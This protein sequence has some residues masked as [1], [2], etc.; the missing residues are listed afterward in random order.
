MS[1]QPADADDASD[2]HIRVLA[3]QKVEPIGILADEVIEPPVDLSTMFRTLD[4]F[5]LLQDEQQR[6]RVL[7]AGGFGDVYLANDVIL[8]RPVAVKLLKTE[9]ATDREQVNQFFQEGVLTSRLQHPGILPVHAMGLWQGRPAI[10]MKVVDGKTLTQYLFE[11]RQSA[12]LSTT[13]VVD[14][15]LQV[16]RAVAYAHAQLTLH[17]DLKPSNVMIGAQDEI[18]VMDWGLGRLGENANQAVHRAGTPAYMPPEQ[19]RGITGEIG[20]ATDVFSLGAMLTEILTGKPP[21][22]ATSKVRMIHMAQTADL[23]ECFQR[24]NDLEN[25]DPALA[26]LTGLA[27]WCLS[28]KAEQRPR[29]AGMVV[30]VLTNYQEG[31][32]LQVQQEIVDRAEREQQALVARARA[33]AR[34]TILSTVALVVFVAMATGIWRLATIQARNAGFQL[35]LVKIGQ[36]IRDGSPVAMEQ[37]RRDLAVLTSRTADG[38]VS[39]INQQLMQQAQADLDF[40]EQRDK[41]RQS[42]AELTNGME[43]NTGTALQY[44]A[45]FEQYGILIKEPDDAVKRIRSSR[46]RPELLTGLD[47]WSLVA[48]DIQKPLLWQ[49]ARDA[50]EPGWFQKFRT[51]VLRSDPAALRVL[52]SELPWGDLRA[53]EFESAARGL[54]QQGLRAES[55]TVL[56]KAVQRYPNDFWLN[57][58]LGQEIAATGSGPDPLK[59][60][61]SHASEAVS[62]LRAALA[63]K[64]NAYVYTEIARI[65][66]AGGD[67]DVAEVAAN[68]ALKIDI[69][70]I[71]ARFY[72]AKIQSVRN[73]PGQAASIARQA[74]GMVASQSPMQQSEWSRRLNEFLKQMEAAADDP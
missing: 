25:L 32:R 63:L 23:G 15:F 47:H 46:I 66:L 61:A 37:A 27:R 1:P 52:V 51:P 59:I 12:T 40:I 68:Q 49:V 18:Q 72:L 31:L 28:E 73:E 9:H 19:A 43:L 10:V 26:P 17:L 36:L 33:R 11:Q 69:N 35:D 65:A 4:G 38:A 41:V 48:D 62:Y 67:L 2:L 74:L 50:S 7:G 39:R 60:E 20:P 58:L 29:D 16:C 44:G 5:E 42:L 64:E 3:V 53:D 57:L 34:T 30:D 6:P 24:L 54:S 55:L 45:L 56:R 22:L 13:K 71:A 70:A 8:N 21:Y 14:Y